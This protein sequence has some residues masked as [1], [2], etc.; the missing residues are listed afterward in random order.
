[1]GGLQGIAMGGIKELP[2]AER[3]AAAI[4]AIGQYCS[5]QDHLETSERKLCY[6]LEPLRQTTARSLLMGMTHPRICKKLSK[7]NP[8]ICT[9][10]TVTVT[11][12]SQRKAMSFSK[13]R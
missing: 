9:L 13:S 11:S 1:M 10:E 3:E 8:D 5:Q 4:T 6:Y 7:E 2:K 12:A